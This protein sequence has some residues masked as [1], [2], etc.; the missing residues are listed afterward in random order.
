MWGA[1]KMIDVGVD[2]LFFG[3]EARN[4][5]MRF[6]LIYAIIYIHIQVYNTQLNTFIIVYSFSMFH[7]LSNK[8]KSVVG[9]SSLQVA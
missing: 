9:L 2:W 3:L 5:N 6:W 7:G 1:I 4:N 8:Q